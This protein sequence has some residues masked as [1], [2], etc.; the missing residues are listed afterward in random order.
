M[1]GAGDLGTGWGGRKG[2]S[3]LRLGGSKLR[4]QRELGQGLETLLWK[5]GGIAGE[6]AGEVTWGGRRGVPC[7]GV[8]SAVLTQGARGPAPEGLWGRTRCWGRLG[9][10]WGRGLCCA[11]QQL[12]NRSH[13]ARTGCQPL[14]CLAAPCLGT[15]SESRV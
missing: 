8:P 3:C 9:A 13:F 14:L 10:A 1:P 15:A 12:T 6:G 7:T 4:V 2:T 5:K 11:T